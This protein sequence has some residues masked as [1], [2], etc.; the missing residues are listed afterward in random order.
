MTRIRRQEARTLEPAA[1][2]TGRLRY[3]LYRPPGYG[4]DATRRWP[5]LLYLHGAGERGEDLGI[6]ANHGPPR[7]IEEG[8]DFTALV[9]SP[10]C[11][12]NER[13]SPAVLA[14][15]LDEIERT[16]RVDV[17]RLYVTG[18]SMGGF[19]TWALAIAQPQ[20]FAALA[21]ICGG[22]NPGAVGA[23]RHLPVWTFHGAKDDIVPL[24]RTEEMVKALQAAGGAVRFTVHPEAWHDSWTETY[25]D[26]EFWE[27]L[28]A[29]QRQ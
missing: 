28:F 2:R 22:G 24:R 10:Q 8:Q 26:P 23:I 4:A 12:P 7:L 21:P 15:L 20:R 6:V 5:L 1:T 18:I 3:L 27:W 29:Q 11:G 14:A 13:W 19:G 9:A 25:T 16:E 17:G